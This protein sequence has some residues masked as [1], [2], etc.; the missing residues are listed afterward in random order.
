MSL[1]Q[2][3]RAHNCSLSCTATELSV[4]QALADHRTLVQYAG[5]TLASNMSKASAL[6]EWRAFGML[7]AMLTVAVVKLADEGK[8]RVDRF[9]VASVMLSRCMIQHQVLPM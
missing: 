9:A 8:V 5:H 1:S 6:L 2:A 7:V 4:W 3:A